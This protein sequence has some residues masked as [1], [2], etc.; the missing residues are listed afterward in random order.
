MKNQNNKLLNELVEKI[1]K[2]D[3]YKIILFGSYASGNP[4]PESDI[5]LIVIMDENY[6]PTTF[7]ERTKL[8]SRVSNVITDI[9]KKVPI[10][11]IVYT[12]TMYIKFLE[13]GSVF[14]REVT[15]KGIVLYE[16]DYKRVA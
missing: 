9:R 8:T 15:E 3:P 1:K 13:M 4:D 11:L 7:K 5:D 12:K 10:D 14:S 16:K 6:L 2:L